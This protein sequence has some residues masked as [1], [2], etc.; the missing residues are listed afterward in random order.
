MIPEE[1]EVDP[2][3]TCCANCR[4]FDS[5]PCFCRLNPPVPMTVNMGGY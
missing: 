3:A 1:Y 2:K 5:R 4:W